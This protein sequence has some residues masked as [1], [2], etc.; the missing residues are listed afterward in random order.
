MLGMVKMVLP[1]LING[2]AKNADP[3]MYVDF[4]LDQCPASAYD[5]LRTFLL[6]GD[7]LDQLATIEPGIRFQQDWWISLR[8]GLLEALNEELG[9][10]IRT[11]QPGETSE[12]TT[13]TPTDS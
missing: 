11:L 12:P 3:S 8:S 4:L 9:H 6:K 1:A 2:A 13:G 7:C 10:A 5:S